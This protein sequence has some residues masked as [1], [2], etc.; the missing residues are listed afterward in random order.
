MEEGI[1]YELIRTGDKI[2]RCIGTIHDYGAGL[3]C[4]DIIALRLP[5]R[6]R[7]TALVCT[8]SRPVR[9]QTAVIRPTSNPLCILASVC[10]GSSRHRSLSRR[11]MK[12][13]GPRNHMSS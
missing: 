5:P 1:G 6:K 8:C 10:V 4:I 2:S 11:V 13:S 3:Q 12:A 7:L 9:N